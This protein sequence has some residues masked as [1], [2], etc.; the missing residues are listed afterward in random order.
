MK[1]ILAFIMAIMMLLGSTAMAEFDPTIPTDQVT[2]VLFWHSFTGDNEA[3][4]T[5]Q[6]AAFEAQYPYIDVNA[7]YIGGYNVIHTELAS[8]NAAGTGVPALCVINVPR[9]TSYAQ[10]GLVEDL[11][12]YIDAF[13]ADINFDDFYPGMTDMMNNEGHQTALPFGQSGQIFYYNK[14]LLNEIGVSFPTKMEEMDA[15]LETVYNYTGKPVL[16]VHGT[17]NA[18]FYCMFTNMGAFMI[19]TETNTTGLEN[20]AALNLII[21]IREWVDKGWVKWVINDVGNTLTLD[22][23]S[24]AVASILYTSSSYAG[25]KKKADNGENGVTFEVGIANQ[26]Y[27]AAGTNHQYVAGATLIIPANECNTEAQKAAAFQLACFLTAPTQQLAWAT[28]SSYYVTRQSAA[29]DPQYAD[30]YNGLLGKLPEMASID[31]NS[32]V[33]KTKH[34]LFDKCGDIFETYMSEIM[35][36]GMDPTEGWELMCEEINDTLADQ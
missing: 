12:P 16:A 22:F 30:A 27:G 24:G 8:A 25:Y 32:Y 33:A 21:K 1:K 3:I 10:D 19:D 14:T 18:Y 15:F 29:T 34:P 36:N 11:T 20:D 4:L 5:E 6:I 2:E 26:P 31:L 17:D 9:L 7:Q 28:T 13:A 35:T 23:T